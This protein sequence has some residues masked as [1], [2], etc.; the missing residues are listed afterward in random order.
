VE[1]FL[2][3]HEIVEKALHDELRLHDIHAHQM[4]MRAE[5]GRCAIASL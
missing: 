2:L 1:P 5:R 3:T 4:A